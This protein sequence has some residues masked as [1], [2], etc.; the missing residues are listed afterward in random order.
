MHVH[1]SHE[2]DHT[3][4]EGKPNDII[5]FGPGVKAVAMP[6]KTSGRN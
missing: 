5:L 4:P 1:V 3:R 2:L 6:N